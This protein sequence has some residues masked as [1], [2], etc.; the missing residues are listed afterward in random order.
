MTKE[1]FITKLK[2]CVDTIHYQSHELSKKGKLFE[3]FKT[4]IEELQLYLTQCSVGERKWIEKQTTEHMLK[5]L[6]KN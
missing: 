5:I 6:T 2:D 4:T 1:Q 3:K